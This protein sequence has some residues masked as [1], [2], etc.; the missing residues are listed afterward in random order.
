[1]LEDMKCDLTDD[2]Q[3]VIIGESMGG[4]IGRY[5]LTY[6]ETEYYQNKITS[7][8]FQDAI[9][10]NN[11]PYLAVHPEIYFLPTHW[12]KTVKMHNT[13]LLITLDTPHQGAN[14]PISAQLAYKNAMQAISLALGVNATMYFKVF[15]LFLDC[16][17]A[18][19]MLIYHVDTRSILPV[20]GSYHSYDSRDDKD[21]FFGQLNS[22][23]NYPQYAKVVAMSNGSLKGINQC[24][25]GPSLTPPFINPPRIPGDRLIDFGCEIYGRVLG[26]KIPLF[27]ADVKAYTNPNGL[28]K[29]LQANAGNYGVHIKL[30][31]FGIKVTV[32]YVTLFVI[33]E[34]AISKPYCTSAGGFI[35][36]EKFLDATASASSFNTSNNYWMLNF[37]HYTRTTDGLGCVKFDSHLG[38]NG[39]FSANFDYHL[40]S[41]GLQFCFVPVQSALDYGVLGFIPLDHD[42]E[43]ENIGTKLNMVK[44]D[45]II[46][47]PGNYPKVNNGHVGFRNDYIYNIT[48][49]ANPATSAYLF[50]YSSCVKYNDTVERGIIN[51]E[52]GDEELYLENVTLPW[53]GAYE[54]EF[55][56]HVNER[57]PH[58]Q[59]S[60]TPISPI[61]STVIPGIYSQK[62]DYNINVTTGQGTFYVNKTYSPANIGLNYL[63]PHTGPVIKV[64]Q[65][66]PVCCINFMNERTANE[67][68]ATDLFKDSYLHA[69]P[70]PNNGNQLIL[71]YRLKKK[72]QAT[73][74]FFDVLGKKINNNII[75]LDN[76][77]EENTETINLSN[78]D[79]ANGMYWVRITNGTEVV[80]T[81]LIINK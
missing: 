62:E 50:T 48:N 17:A 30:K 80:G 5:L 13:R 73:V 28:G 53:K 52:I 64:E 58:Y 25:Y 24:N 74:E 35:G 10:L 7:P 46:G 71:N 70:N 44:A 68:K 39:L 18:Q 66:L 55:D 75:K 27:G 6:M 31:L 45:V 69:Y 1:M 72:T 11:L 8:F 3:F 4:L 60:S 65:P 56:I 29:V 49:A 14:L 36:D 40:C 21:H 19:Q 79:L 81:K 42:I 38:L 16:Q 23:G 78:Y 54:A 43:I 47:Y 26:I 77:V 33:D 34:D 12:C 22:M 20:I 15:N 63:S 51:M 32:G 67:V 57:N 2:Q 76:K 9:D 37:F 41:D 61:P 59:Y